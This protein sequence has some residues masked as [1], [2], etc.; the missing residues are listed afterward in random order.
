[1]GL[2]INAV[3]F[4]VGA[5]KRG[6][7]FD[8]V[9]MI[10]RQ[11]LNVYPAKMVKVLGAAGLPSEAFKSGGKETQFAEPLFQA[12]GG[13]RVF[14]LDASDYEGAEFTH[15]LNKPIPTE[16]RGRFDAVYDGGTLEHV[17]N[18]PVALQSCMEMV[19]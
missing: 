16:W 14:S 19:K 7:R 9:L 11:D 13:K 10:G 3:Q 15:D 12:L 8:E 5:H 6:A 17:F 18:F 1:M 2:D 4:L